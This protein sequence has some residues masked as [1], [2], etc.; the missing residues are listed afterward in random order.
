MNAKLLLLTLLSVF[1]LMGCARTGTPK[2]PMG[3]SR[4]S[5][6]SEYS[7]SDFQSDYG[8]YKVAVTSQNLEAALLLRDRMINRIEADVE[9][10]Y[11]EYEAKIF[12]NRATAN[13]A[14]DI[15][16]LGVSASIGVAEETVVKDLLAAALT[17]FKG[18]RLSFDKNFFRE[19]TTEI[20]IA[21]MQ[22]YRD[23]VRNR[24]T[25]KMSQLSARDYPFE[26][27][28]RD[29]IEHF[30]A[31]TLQGGL[32]ALANDA[33]QD[34]AAAKK[35]TEDL[36]TL[37]TST[38][39][40]AANALRI[41]TTFNEWYNAVFTAPID[42]AKAA[43]ATKNAREALKSLTG[44]DV[45]DPV[46]VFNR[47]DKEIRRARKEPERFNELLKAFKLSGQ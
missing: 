9:R 25:S 7:A 33:G 22:A 11:R 24:I 2:I 17:S 5:A 3:V 40:R 30:F 43:E 12:Y 19:K 41:R 37:R 39:E 44:E 28:W 35:D 46:Q 42:N 26:E 20:I 31:G 47:L 15:V 27:A 8:A 6:I 4:A 10:N 34:A 45:S 36:E 1:L 29:L 16:E 32:Q 38:P 21:K 18:T 14:A 23:R 13:V